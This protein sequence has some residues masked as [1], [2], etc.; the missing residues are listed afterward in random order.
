MTIL[1]TTGL[2]RAV[3]S[4]QVF[5]LHVLYTKQGQDNGQDTLLLF[6]LLLDPSDKLP[7]QRYPFDK[8]RDGDD[9]PSVSKPSVLRV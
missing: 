8:L 1:L 2:N 7:F 6:H 3:D 9:H 4:S 5:V